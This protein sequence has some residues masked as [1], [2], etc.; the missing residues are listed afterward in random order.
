A[1][2]KFG[3]AGVNH[4]GWLYDIRQNGRNLVSEF[5]SLSTGSVTF[6]PGEL[7]R[8]YAAVPLKD[9]RYHYFGKEVAAEQKRA[10]VHRA[11]ELQRLQ[12][13][14]ME[15][16]SVGNYYEINNALNERP[17]PWY[18]HAIAPFVANFTG[19]KQNPTVFFLTK[20]NEGYLPQFQDDDIIEVPHLTQQN[21]FRRVL[22]HDTPPPHIIEP[23]QKYVNYER[24]ATRAI[25][26]GSRR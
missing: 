6:P 20:R 17:A 12:A 3:Y 19:L 7:V 14:A 5:S 25:S 18:E 16:F 11:R 13:T 22:A 8:D 10:P 23:L 9:L 1:R 2:V 15:A 4:L 21:A 24:L 26:S